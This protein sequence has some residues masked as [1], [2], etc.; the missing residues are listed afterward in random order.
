MGLLAASAVCPASVCVP[1][2]ALVFA[3]SA[4][5]LDIVSIWF[6][7]FQMQNSRL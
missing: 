5:V 4:G 7:P 6:Y 1:R 2:S 3:R